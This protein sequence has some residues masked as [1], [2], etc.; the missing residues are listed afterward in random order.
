[1]YWRLRLVVLMLQPPKGISMEGDEE[2]L[3]DIE[4]NVPS[5]RD[6]WMATL[7]PERKTPDSCARYLEAYNEATAIASN[8]DDKRMTADA[9]LV[10]MYNKAK[11]SKSLVEKH[12]KSQ[13]A[14]KEEVKAAACGE[15]GLGGESSLETM[16]SGEGLGVWETEGYWCPITLSLNGKGRRFLSMIVLQ[17]LWLLDSDV[18]CHILNKLRSL[19]GHESDSRKLMMIPFDHLG[20]PVPSSPSARRIPVVDNVKLHVPFDIG[21]GQ[22]T[23]SLSFALSLSH[24]KKNNLEVSNKNLSWLGSPEID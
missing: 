9:E 4:V 11:R 3:V 12:Q 7:S 8:E 15:R 1:M 14:C 13:R 19:T 20:M 6:E 22:H 24:R 21:I 18:T 5:K 16:G 2:L 17:A 10:D 23:S